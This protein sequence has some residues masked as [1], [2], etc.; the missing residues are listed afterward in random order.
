MKN[1]HTL[2]VSKQTKRQRFR[3]IVEKPY[4]KL[5]L[6][7]GVLLYAGFV[8]VYLFVAIASLYV[9]ATLVGIS[10]IQLLI[11][12]VSAGSAVA[13]ASAAILIWRGNVQARKTVL[14]DRVLG[15]SYAEVRKWREL[16]EAW[17]TEAKEHALSMPFLMQVGSPFSTRK[18][19][20]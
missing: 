10:T 9:F 14:I 6:I 8:V 7:F 5:P 19:R 4:V 2:S 18:K 3:A 16:L 13:S 17:K 20:R 15:P 1:A 11:G 12:A